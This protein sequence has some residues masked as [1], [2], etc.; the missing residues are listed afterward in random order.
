MVSP[1]GQLPSLLRRLVQTNYLDEMTAIK[2]FAVSKN[3]AIGWIHTLVQQ[4]LVSAYVIAKMVAL[5]LGLPVFDLSSLDKSQL[6]QTYLQIP[7]L[8][9]RRILPC[10]QQGQQLY[11]ALSD[12]MQLSFLHEC[13]FATNKKC[14]GIVVQADKLNDLID[15]VLKDQTVQ[16][17][18][19]LS[20]VDEVA[21]LSSKDLANP[22]TQATDL[23]NDAPVVQFINHMLQDAATQAISDIHLESYADNYRIRFRRDGLLYATTAPPRQLAKRLSTRIKVMAHL[24]IAEQRLPQ[25]GQFHVPLS[26]G[27][28]ISCRVSTCPTIAGEKV[29]I[30]LLDPAEHLR[31]IAALGYESYQ[32][33]LLL[34]CLKLPQGM[35]LVTGPTGSGKT[36]SLYAALQWLNNET[37]NIITL[38]DPVEIPLS[39]I[40]QVDI[41]DKIDFGFAKALPALLRQDPD[42]IMVGEM[43]DHATIDIAIKAAQTGHLV[44][45]TLHTNSAAETITRLLQMDVA[46]YELASAITLI[47]AQR[48]VRSLC[49]YCRERDE[50]SIAL[51]ITCCYR[52]SKDGC[53][54]CQKGYQGRIALYEMLSVTPTIAA[55]ILQGMH[56]VDIEKLAIEQG[57]QTLKQSGLHK[58]AQGLTSLAEVLRVCG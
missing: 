1:L 6:P 42:V 38:E 25:D 9:K 47:I 54:H 28:E 13:Q 10:Y 14:L 29:V 49:I 26:H 30:R 43:R 3:H 8:K 16:R 51:N 19:H 58:V 53:Q 23:E 39:G 56:A 52:A 21:S 45:S 44:L 41:N 7:W 18:S 40:N 15:E 22:L 46:A 11:V 37:R 20:I 50:P 36:V 48:L 31:S 4:K 17:L 34:T 5:E 27:R 35:I 32:Q 33:D 57:M 2:Q 55:A 24:D 12:P